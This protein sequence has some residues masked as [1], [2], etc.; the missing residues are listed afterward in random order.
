MKGLI[1]LKRL[2]TEQVVGLMKI[3]Q[4]YNVSIVAD[5]AARSALEHR[6]KILKTVALLIDEKKRLFSELSSPAFKPYLR[7]VPSQANFVLCE[8][9]G[10]CPVTAVQLAQGLRKK[11]III[12]YFGTQ[13]S[14]HFSPQII[15]H[16]FWFSNM[17]FRAELYKTTFAYHLHCLSIQIGSSLC[18]RTSSFLLKKR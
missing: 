9:L 6:E 5:A 2:C 10:T 1:S 12:R 8:V 14:Y 17:E 18:S 15:A 11:G 3:K 13:V 16:P 4:P 7:P